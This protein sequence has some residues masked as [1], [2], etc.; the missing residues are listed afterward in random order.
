[1]LALGAA[2]LLLAFFYTAGSVKYKYRG[3]GEIGVFL[4]YGPF[5]V[6][7]TA[8]IQTGRFLVPALFFSVPVGLHVVAILFANNMRDSANDAKAGALTLARLLGGRG[9]LTFYYVLVF[10]PY[11]LII[12]AA[13]SRSA[14]LALPVL[15]APLAWGLGEDARKG[16]L[17]LLPQKT[18]RFML[19]FGTLLVAC[20]ALARHAA[21]QVS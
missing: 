21:F 7:G 1:M 19:V 12:A 13:V 11:L 20:I 15:S 3:L 9:S 2:G 8:L 4:C 6:V 5:L 10:A 18:A 17:S 14:W 16:D